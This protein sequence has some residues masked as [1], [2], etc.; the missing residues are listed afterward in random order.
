MNNEKI[1]FLDLVKPHLE[2]ESELLA[3]FQKVLRSAVFINGPMVSEFEEAFASFCDTRFAVAVSS[4]TDALRF[5]LMAAGVGEDS[6]VVTVPN[7]F[8]ATTEA[9]SQV[10]ATPEFV[11]VDEHTYNMDAQKLRE[12]LEH[13]CSSDY[14]GNLVSRRTGRVVRAVI[15]V[16]LYGQCVDMDAIRQLVDRYNLTLIEDACQAHGAEYYSS[17]DD[18]WKKAGSIGKAGAFSFYPGKNLGACGE[19]GAV[20]TDDEEVARKIRMIRDHGQAKKYYHDVEGYNGRLDAVQA[21]ILSVKLQYLREWNEKRRQNAQRYHNLFASEPNVTLPF[22]HAWSKAV[23]HLYVVQVENRERVMA[24]LNKKDISC[25]IHYPIPLHLQKAYLGL[26]Y[27]RGDFPVCEA[28]SSR[29]V[30]LP[31]SPDISQ[32]DQ[33]RVARALIKAVNDNVAQYASRA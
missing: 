25:A 26:G 32:T 30:S 29:I 14:A 31:M 24:C 8:I 15:P 27:R 17:Q 1:S 33:E 19:A 22:E 10:G 28:A 3:V 9:I 18:V 7:T 2:L 20:T 23:Y 21:G 13:Q 5:A 4:G 6:S 16:H 12:F 11:D